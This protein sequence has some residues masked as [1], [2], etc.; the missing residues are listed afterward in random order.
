MI[1]T[2]T[3]TAIQ[4]NRT[5]IVPLVV[6]S[7]MMSCCEWVSIELSVSGECSEP[8]DALKPL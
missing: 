7:E 8:L 3:L 2:F 1:I 4:P 6:L 5:D